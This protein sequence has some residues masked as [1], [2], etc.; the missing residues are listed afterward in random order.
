MIRRM[1]DLFVGTLTAL[2]AAGVAL[3]AS[4]GAPGAS[5]PGKP[6]GQAQQN[7]DQSAKAASDEITRQRLLNE[8]QAQ[9]IKDLENSR[10][11]P[12]ADPDATRRHE[13]LL[14]AERAKLK[15]AED[16]RIAA[17]KKLA[18]M[19][20]AAAA[21]DAAGLQAQ[22]DALKAEN[23]QL[24]VKL[25]SSQAACE[26]DLANKAEKQKRAGNRIRDLRAQEHTLLDE[27]ARL[28]A[29]GADSGRI[30]Q[31]EQ[32]IA[33]VRAEL[34]A[35]PTD[36][37]VMLLKKDI[38]DLDE[39]IAKFP[40]NDALKKQRAEIWDKLHEAE[41]DCDAHI[42]D[43][44][45]EVQDLEDENAALKQKNANLERTAAATASTVMLLEKDIRDLDEQIAKFPTDE[46]LKRK[47]AEIWE[48]LNAAKKA[49]D[50]KDAEIA[51]LKQELA[52]RPSNSDVML[53]E[54]D[55]RD[56][57]EQIAKFPTD[58]ELKRK[59]AEIWEKLNAS[60]LAESNCQATM[61]AKESEIAAL[62]KEKEQLITDTMLKNKDIRD[63]DEQIAKFPSNEDLKKQRADIW[64]KV[65]RGKEDLAAHAGALRD[66]M[67]EYISDVDELQA[68][69]KAAVAK[70][71][72]NVE[73]IK[74]E[75]EEVQR[76]R[77]ALETALKIAQG[78]NA[79]LTAQHIK[80]LEDIKA[81]A[82][83][84]ESARVAAK[85]I[86]AV[87]DSVAM[88]AEKKSCQAKIAE[89]DARISK[90][91]KDLAAMKPV[92]MPI[93]VTGPAE[94]LDGD[95]I[96]DVLE[97]VLVGFDIDND[98]RVSD[99]IL[100]YEEKF[101]AQKAISD[102]D[103]AELEDRLVEAIG[104]AEEAKLENERLVS[105][106]K[107][108]AAALAGLVA[109]MSMMEKSKDE[110]IAQQ[111]AHVASL[112]AQIVAAQALH[113]QANM[114][115]SAAMINLGK[116]LEMLA[117]KDAKLTAHAVQAAQAT[118]DAAGLRAKVEDIRKQFDAARTA[119][120]QSSADK[121]TLLAYL[122]SKIIELQ[123]EKDLTAELEQDIQELYDA[124]KNGGTV[125][126]DWTVANEK[127][128]TVEKI[129]NVQ[130]D[131]EI[132]RL[133]QK[134]KDLEAELAG[135]DATI[136]ANKTLLEDTAK[137]LEDAIKDSANHERVIK[138]L[139]VLNM[140]LRDMLKDAEQKV[141][142]SSATAGELKAAKEEIANINFLI[143]GIIGA[144]PAAAAEPNDPV[145]PAA[146]PGS[147]PAIIA[148][149]RQFIAELQQ[150]I[151]DLE[152]AKIGK[153]IVD[154]SDVTKLQDRIAELEK[155]LAGSRGQSNVRKL[156]L[157]DARKK[158]EDA[159]ADAKDQRDLV[160]KLQAIIT[161]LRSKLRDVAA[162]S[163]NAINDII[164]E[165]IAAVPG[166]VPADPAIDPQESP[167]DRL[168]QYIA[169]LLAMIAALNVKAGSLVAAEAA[170]ADAVNSIPGKPPVTPNSTVPG[171][172]IQQYI[173]ELLQRIRE[174]EAQGKITL[175]IQTTLENG[176]KEAINAANDPSA[177]AVPDDA[178]PDQLVETLKQLIEKLKKR[179]AELENEINVN[180]KPDDYKL[181]DAEVKELKRKIRA[182][183]ARMQGNV[184]P[185]VDILVA[186]QEA[187]LGPVDTNDVLDADLEKEIFKLIGLLM[188]A[189][190]KLNDLGVNKPGEYETK[191]KE[192]E[193]NT[194]L[195][196]DL[197]DILGSGDVAGLKAAAENLKADLEEAVRKLRECDEEKAA[198]IKKVSDLEEELRVCNETD[199]CVDL[200]NQIA[201]L[202]AIIKKL[203]EDIV[204]LTAENEKLKG[205]VTSISKAL[206]KDPQDFSDID[207][208]ELKALIDKFKADLL[209]AQQR[210]AELEALLA[211]CD[212]DKELMKRELEL[213][214]EQ[215]KRELDIADKTI[216]ALMT[217]LTATNAELDQLRVEVNNKR[218]QIRD[219]DTEIAD[220]KKQLRAAGGKNA[221][222]QVQIKQ[223]SETREKFRTEFGALKEEFLRL[224]NMIHAEEKRKREE[225]EAREGKSVT[226]A[227]KI[228]K[229]QEEAAAQ[230]AAQSSM[231]EQE[232]QNAL[233]ALDVLLTSER[234][235]MLTTS[236]PKPNDA[237][238]A[239][240]VAKA[241][242]LPEAYVPRVKEIEKLYNRFR[243]AIPKAS[244]LDT[245]M[246]KQSGGGDTLTLG[247]L[248]TEINELKADIDGYKLEGIE[249]PSLQERL[250]EAKSTLEDLKRM[251]FPSKQGA[252]IATDPMEATTD[253]AGTEPME[254]PSEDVSNAADMLAMLMALAAS[255]GAH[256]AGASEFIKKQNGKKNLGDLVRSAKFAG[257]LGMDQAVVDKVKQDV[258]EQI[259][260]IIGNLDSKKDA[261]DILFTFNIMGSEGYTG[262]ALA[263]VETKKNEV[264]A[265]YEAG[266][267]AEIA[268]EKVAGAV[269]LIVSAT[270]ID[271]FK[272]TDLLSAI[273]IA[274][275][276]IDNS[277][278]ANVVALDN[279]Q[280]KFDDK[281]TEDDAALA[282][283]VAAKPAAAS[284]M[285]NFITK[286][287]GVIGSSDVASAR[288]TQPYMDAKAEVDKF[289]ADSKTNTVDYKDALCA[290]IQLRTDEL[291]ASVAE[292]RQA[293]TGDNVTSFVAK[294]ESALR[295]DDYPIYPADN[296]TF[297]GLSPLNQQRYGAGDVRTKLDGWNAAYDDFLA[298]KGEAAQ[299][300]ADLIATIA[301]VPSYDDCD[302]AVTAIKDIS[303]KRSKLLTR[304]GRDAIDAKLGDHR[305]ALE[306]LKTKLIERAKQAA[307]ADM[308]ANKKDRACIES[309]IFEF[310]K[311]GSDTSGLEVAIAD[312]ESAISLSKPVDTGAS[313]EKESRY[314]LSQVPGMVSAAKKYVPESKAEQQVDAIKNF[315]GDIPDAVKGSTEYSNAILAMGGLKD[316]AE[317][318]SQMQGD[319]SGAQSATSVADMKRKHMDAIKVPRDVLLE[320]GSTVQ[321]TPDLESQDAMKRA[322]E[323]AAFDKKPDLYEEINDVIQVKSPKVRVYDEP[324]MTP[325]PV[326][327]TSLKEADKDTGRYKDTSDPDQFDMFQKV[328]VDRNEQILTNKVF[329][330]TMDAVMKGE[331]N[332]TVD[333]NMKELLLDSFQDGIDPNH[334][335]WLDLATLAFNVMQYFNLAWYG[336]EANRLKDPTMFESIFKSSTSSEKIR[337]ALSKFPG[338]FWHPEESCYA[339]QH[340]CGSVSPAMA[341]T[342]REVRCTDT[343][344][345]NELIRLS[346]KKE[347]FANTRSHVT[348]EHCLQMIVEGCTARANFTSDSR[349]KNPLMHFVKEAAEAINKAME[350]VVAF[351]DLM[352]PILVREKNNPAIRDVFKKRNGVISYV[353]F[354][355]RTS[356]PVTR[357]D[358]KVYNP[359]N[360]GTLPNFVT[361]PYKSQ[362]F[363]RDDSDCRWITETTETAMA[364]G[365]SKHVFSY[366]LGPFTAVFHPGNASTPMG[367]N[368]VAKNCKELLTSINDDKNVFI[369]GYGPSGAG[370]TSALIN[371]NGGKTQDER[372]GIIPRILADIKDIESVQVRLVEYFDDGTGER[373][374]DLC[375]PNTVNPPLDTVTP[376]TF[377]LNDSKT[378][379]VT[380]DV[381][382]LKAAITT[383]SAT[384][385]TDLA[386]VFAEYEANINS[387]GGFM[388][389]HLD[390]VRRVDPTTNNPESSRS[391]V[392]MYLDIIRSG[393]KTVKMAIG[394]FAG[395]ESKFDCDNLI[396]GFET[397]LVNAGKEGK[398]TNLIK[399]RRLTFPEATAQKY[400]SLDIN[401]G[402]RQDKELSGGIPPA[403]RFARDAA[404]KAA[405]SED[406]PMS[407][408]EISQAQS[409]MVATLNEYI[410]GH[411]EN[412]VKIAKGLTAMTY[413]SSSGNRYD[414]IEFEAEGGTVK[415]VS[416][417]ERGKSAVDSVESMKNLVSYIDKALGSAYTGTASGS[418]KMRADQ[419][420]IL[421]VEDGVKKYVG[422]PVPDPFATRVVSPKAAAPPKVGKP[423]VPKSALP[424]SNM[425][426]ASYPGLM[427]FGTVPVAEWLDDEVEKVSKLG[428]DPTMRSWASVLR[429]A[430]V[431]LDMVDVNAS[432]EH[433]VW[434]F[435][436][437]FDSTTAEELKEYSEA[438]R[439]WAAK[440]VLQYMGL[441]R[442]CMLRSKEGVYIVDSLEDV[443]NYLRSVMSTFI[444]EGKYA[445]QYNEAC[446]VQICN[447]VYGS[448]SKN[449][450]SREERPQAAYSPVKLITKDIR[451]YTDSNFVPVIMTVVNLEPK[452]RKDDVSGKVLADI[453]PPPYVDI[454]D[455]KHINA[456]RKY[457]GDK[458]TGGW[459]QLLAKAHD[460]ARLTNT[461]L[462]LSS[463]K[464]KIVSDLDN[465]D[466]PE[467]IVAA[468][469]LLAT[470]VFYLP[471]YDRQVEL[472]AIR[473]VQR[474]LAYLAD[475]KGA[476]L[477][478]MGKV[479]DALN[480]LAECA[481]V[482]DTDKM[483]KIIE[484]IDSLNALSIVGCLEFTDQFSKFLNN[485]F[486][487]RQDTTFGT[488]VTAY[489]KSLSCESGDSID[490]I[491]PTDPSAYKFTTANKGE[492]VTVDVDFT[493]S[494]IT[495]KEVT[496]LAH[497]NA[498]IS[499]IPKTVYDYDRGSFYTEYNYASALLPE[500]WKSVKDTVM[501]LAV[502]WYYRSKKMDIPSKYEISGLTCKL[503]VEGNMAGQLYKVNPF[504]AH[505][506]DVTSL[507]SMSA[508]EGAVWN[509]IKDIVKAG[510][511]KYKRLAGMDGKTNIDASNFIPYVN[512]NSSL[513]ESLIEGVSLNNKYM[514]DVDE[515]HMGDAGSADVDVGRPVP[516]A[517]YTKP[518]ATSKPPPAAETNA[519]T[520]Q[521]ETAVIN[522][523]ED[524]KASAPRDAVSRDGGFS[525]HKESVLSGGKYERTLVVAST[526]GFNK[527]KVYDKDY[528]YLP[529]MVP[530]DPQGRVTQNFEARIVETPATKH[531]MKSMLE[532]AISN[533]KYGMLFAGFS[534][535]D[536]GFKGTGM[537]HTEAMTMFMCPLGARPFRIIDEVGTLTD[538]NY[539]KVHDYLSRLPYGTVNCSPMLLKKC[540]SRVPDQPLKQSDT[541]EK[542]WNK[543]LRVLKDGVKV[544][545]TSVS[546]ADYSNDNLD[547]EK[548]MILEDLLALSTVVANTPEHLLILKDVP[549][550]KPSDKV[551]L[552]TNLYTR[553]RMAFAEFGPIT[554]IDDRFAKRDAMV[555]E[556][557]AEQAKMITGP[558]SGINGAANFGVSLAYINAE[559]PRKDAAGFGNRMIYPL[560]VLAFY[561]VKGKNAPVTDVE[562]MSAIGKI[563]GPESARKSHATR[564]YLAK[565]YVKKFLYEKVGVADDETK[566]TLRAKAYFGKF[567]SLQSKAIFASREVSSSFYEFLEAAPQLSPKNIVDKPVKTIQPISQA[568]RKNEVM[569]TTQ[570][571]RAG[572]EF[573]KNYVSPYRQ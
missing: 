55:I 115:S 284:E 459:K 319:I 268:A 108:M 420:G 505:V 315:I 86:Q 5:A 303:D 71:D 385:S 409:D 264:N 144:A 146:A 508:F 554:L 188:D 289:I 540:N 431:A 336:D 305:A 475:A 550:V 369:F 335:A 223:E 168:K 196:Q 316:L 181:V 101:A 179:I 296:K 511:E 230:A 200:R 390:L 427:K 402:S 39:Q 282:A 37:D 457:I 216:T 59:R 213:A 430:M 17:E 14:N 295:T 562:W 243:R 301:S 120:T 355:R 570:G 215:M 560:N 42:Q 225:C 18:D 70:N 260:I 183:H 87:L 494:T 325:L 212:A 269:R 274:K 309:L 137:E 228:K 346:G 224:V 204:N 283:A 69:L 238:L 193:D 19:Q 271:A 533:K 162:E 529:H 90:L 500:E 341:G 449:I 267:A 96:S 175:T 321:H 293:M 98:N 516:D 512:R 498:S 394:D 299:K 426:A 145:P 362:R 379:L 135:K 568:A 187:D 134:I 378:D 466:T 84:M 370:K 245:G 363:S 28:T 417:M 548:T 41:A 530:F 509:N 561:A 100:E 30:A 337:G 58:E 393:G 425:P 438:Y 49:A 424:V 451:D 112:N 45:D 113:S 483:T 36:S 440:D 217:G 453:A 478:N 310:K 153:V 517:A 82:D 462:E 391:H 251:L 235:R 79:T 523:L 357:F 294:S 468:A 141:A 142:D 482:W 258:N 552:R 163:V 497:K 210:V 46:E 522:F 93:T 436:A 197:V 518:K 26:S 124:L 154:P 349:N 233:Q 383:A 460:D 60:R 371:F 307:S 53:L 332:K 339:I 470:P 237:V 382:A 513:V 464:T 114:V 2:A 507:K 161:I 555:D 461:P 551:R 544:S 553:L 152:D 191:K 246:L 455:I 186:S 537:V 279:A 473:L 521:M 129:V 318:I 107:R 139:R 143:N 446:S 302:S 226:E 278:D 259:K 345:Y 450:N 241:Q 266:K 437:M 173:D 330:Y 331:I 413:L 253:D 388:T 456:M 273:D 140:H 1:A 399:S 559:R 510:S 121:D 419:S 178:P 73:K 122:L 300:D 458:Y 170:L 558:V 504:I 117:G 72:A 209:A 64:A 44:E 275:K 249:V 240:A 118:Q 536:S 34:S 47:R 326:T 487:C 492:P 298:A 541:E 479:M 198:L 159:L 131:A 62:K 400:S 231:A 445:V 405:Y 366:H 527:D 189:I 442:E 158:L 166:L 342:L 344:H 66:I 545:Y 91:E 365:S 218:Q 519:L 563:W 377:T 490:F 229:E 76:E 288:Q 528:E 167:I 276:L 496:L 353:R 297:A 526:E 156:L 65:N 94:E 174:L 265:S 361:I 539:A 244:E 31:L 110:I 148:A 239:E 77:D 261:D 286:L 219:K 439:N 109:S 418:L 287:I 566:D 354:T 311:E 126:L 306:A 201:T 211:D 227:A 128:V 116:A 23:E 177:P 192:C 81:H 317:A 89:K 125:V 304:E 499:G 472:A 343:V 384:V 506:K 416:V 491:M 411:V 571:R 4:R 133:K 372:T 397:E 92:T 56:L 314:R 368:L 376:H 157:A 486:V 257:S 9:R 48:K 160:S 222:L 549:G 291:N 556:F 359:P 29:A 184:I 194:K 503:P 401:H 50:A 495:V 381:I 476:R 43:L 351:A 248:M 180:P 285:K 207:I 454:Q 404:M 255:R 327:V 130:D 95:D 236:K 532:S 387:I 242:P 373:R 16:A 322:I 155:E 83:N 169:A 164:G 564:V 203:E 277:S 569:T 338:L 489:A 531:G 150:K 8:Q 38:R 7:Y 543:T 232:R 324:F 323:R 484:I 280:K 99:L 208:E 250:E 25:A 538:D 477:L 515:R 352:Q 447:P 247:E 105:D 364:D 386:P 254:I 256:A 367:N 27:I 176:L 123:K 360:S 535:N 572:A 374:I 132:D 441:K 13:E 407:E 433:C 493:G 403:I 358:V 525:S 520:K 149:L 567:D 35:R 375:S 557:A 33:G 480:L 199:R 334:E 165:I 111:K 15:A 467:R 308:E 422:K 328:Y 104:K 74:A 290:A 313:K 80:D 12:D 127:L 546:A 220:L 54:K 312:I 11:G 252:V 485:D 272:K 214:D 190:K 502:S 347:S 22:I 434:T 206:G 51:A 428:A 421:V 106:K 234:T 136:G 443:R 423:A 350:S 524:A 119:N 6:A 414:P 221:A 292:M 408:S 75:L 138:A 488:A 202:E 103:I 151:K 471:I 406:V 205:H 463:L 270:G 147:D 281:A 40:T 410:G 3:L 396:K 185:G 68:A 171:E 67:D 474:R 356:L 102:A 534:V 565:E 320:D 514:I 52:A 452:E 435:F 32:E 398:P 392:I 389:S 448:C 501:A 412:I 85:A 61:A 10:P 262:D 21:G 380:S 481:T 329:V 333:S 429:D 573:A 432:V 444:S 20:A 78:E 182:L 88:D 63:L 24:A 195:V 547:F 263:I 542:Q 395:V 97:N 172:N 465:N 57:D 415:R 340:C 469:K 348:L